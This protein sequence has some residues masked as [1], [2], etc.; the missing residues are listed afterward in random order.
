VVEASRFMTL[1]TEAIARANRRGGSVRIEQLERGWETSIAVDRRRVTIA[2]DEYLETA[3]MR[4]NAHAEA[5][6]R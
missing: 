3:L 2:R 6:E 4:L 1:L 5:R